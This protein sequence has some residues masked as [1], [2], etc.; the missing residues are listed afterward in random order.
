MLTHRNL[1]SNA[2]ALVEAWGFTRGD[3]LLHALP[4]FHVHGLFVAHALRAA[5][6]A[7]ACC[8]CRSSTR[9][10]SSSLLPRAT[11]MMGV[12]TFYTR[13]LAEP[14]FTRERCRVD[15]AVRVRL[16]AAA[17]RDVRRVPRAHRP[18]DPRALRHDRDRHDHVESARRR[19]GRR[20]RRP[21][22]ARHR[23]A[24]RRR[25]RARRARPASI[26]GVAGARAER[27]RGLLAD[28]GQDARGVHRRRLFPDRRRRAVG[29]ATARHAATCASSAAPRTSSSPAASTSIRRRSRSASTQLDGVVESAVVGVPDPDFGEAVA[30]VVVGKP[31]HTLT[32]SARSSAR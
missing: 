29:R 18:R 28:A 5:R 32:R 6:R 10:R 9:A 12:P 30:A 7:R 20:H 23:R 27:V 2:L 16:G 22:A 3:V 24:H 26:G 1:A 8:G 25:R 4:I 14:A 17:R 31:G 11:V 15:P 13:L 21:A 19:A